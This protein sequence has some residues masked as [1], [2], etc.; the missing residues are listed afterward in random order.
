[1][2]RLLLIAALCHAPFAVAACDLENAESVSAADGVTLQY[3]VKNPPLAPAQHFSL[4]FRVCRGDTPVVVD[5]FK[6]DASMPAHQH[7]MNYRPSVTLEADGLIEASGL[8]F[9]MPGHW[10]VV[11]DL[12]FAGERH[13][14]S[15][16]YQL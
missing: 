7:G 9:H 10:Q 12:E 5:Q 8:L 14:F 15:I 3:R 16:D 6:L 2:I 4:Q 13:Q 1:M 11:A